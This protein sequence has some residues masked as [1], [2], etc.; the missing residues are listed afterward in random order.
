MSVLSLVLDSSPSISEM[1]L[2]AEEVFGHIPYT[3]DI[4]LLTIVEIGNYLTNDLR[5]NGLPSEERNQRLHSYDWELR[6]E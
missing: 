1:K 4:L 6:K 5:H 3:A 2:A